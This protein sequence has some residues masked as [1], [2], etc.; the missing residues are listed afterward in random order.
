MA[1]RRML[2]IKIEDVSRFTV[3]SNIIGSTGRNSDTCRAQ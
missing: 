3:R 1:Q 2:G